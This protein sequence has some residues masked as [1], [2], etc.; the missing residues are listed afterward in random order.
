MCAQLGK[1]HWSSFSPFC[2]PSWNLSRLKFATVLSSCRIPV[3]QYLPL[4]EEE[5]NAFI[6]PNAVTATADARNPAAY[7]TIISWWK[8]GNSRSQLRS[9]ALISSSF[10]ILS[11]SLSNDLKLRQNLIC[12]DVSYIVLQIKEKLHNYFII[13]LTNYSRQH[14]S[15][16]QVCRLL[17]LLFCRQWL[18]VLSKCTRWRWVKKMWVYC[19]QW[20]PIC[21]K[22]SS[23]LIERI[24]EC[25]LPE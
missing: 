16:E 19:S 18:L 20:V 10:V 21:G 24:Y 17:P 14:P 11:L 6:W 25:C 23:Y 9:S 4:F 3:T 2:N 15:L 12:S 5:N 22:K 7:L 8:K 13:K 1:H